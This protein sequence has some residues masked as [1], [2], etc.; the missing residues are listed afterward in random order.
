VIR[1]N[2]TEP[3]DAVWTRWRKDCAKQEPS[4]TDAMTKMMAP[5]I[6]ELY[7][8]KSVKQKH[9]ASITGLFHGKC[10]YCETYVT[11]F[12]KG[13]IEHYRPKLGVTDEK[14]S[15]VT[16]DYGWGPTNHMGYFWLAYNWRNLLLVCADC[17]QPSTVGTD[18]VGKHNRFP[19]TGSYALGPVD[20]PNEQPLLIN[21]LEEEPSDH[22]TINTSD[23]VMQAKNGSAR[24]DATIL[25]L[26]LNVR[27]RIR[28]KRLA[29]IDE[30]K[31]QYA[32]VLHNPAERPQA[33]ARMRAMLNGET[34]Y[35]AAIRAYFNEVVPWLTSFV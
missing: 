27:D 4:V 24:G 7:K 14:D 2:I 17:N 13:D 23:G 35:T 12:Q 15:A 31:T 10:A 34:E 25:I 21:P 32:K 29:A 26:G 11:Q 30:F 28:E 3:T 18:K 8:R 1:I 33:T 9:Y 5:A 16:V 22:L 19:V 6:S 20:V